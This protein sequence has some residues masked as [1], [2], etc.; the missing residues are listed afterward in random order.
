MSA[1]ADHE[2]V[3]AA[4][5]RAAGA[6]ETARA[7]RRWW[8]AEA[9]S[10]YAEHG[11]FLGDDRFVWGPEGLDEE[12]AGLLGP[13]AGL[14]VLEVGA[15]AAQCSRWLARHGAHAI[16]SDLSA[17]MQRR[18]RRID[19][20][21]GTPVP[22]VQADARALPFANGSFDLAVSAYGAV[23]FV[24]DPERVMREVARVLRPGGRWVFSV[25]H[26]LRWALPDDPGA[27]GLVVQHSYF[28]RTPYVEEGDDGTAVYVEHHRTIGD[29]VRDIVAAGL[30]LDDLV[31]PEWPADQHGSWG[32]WSPLRGRLIPGTA[33][34]CCRRPD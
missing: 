12:Q 30:V 5:R 34:F 23:P 26:P 11:G 9:P 13:V 18:G 17:G 29:R 25:T 1:D 16:A 14:R 10:Y 21:L 2:H 19:R 24:G 22:Q 15:G 33:I 28:D 27:E 31:E 3:A 20:R 32:G 4:V 6:D 7:N 8:D